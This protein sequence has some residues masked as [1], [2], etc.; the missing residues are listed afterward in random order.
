MNLLRYRTTE[1]GQ[2]DRLERKVISVVAEGAF[3]PDREPGSLYFLNKK[4]EINLISS[5]RDHSLSFHF[6]QK[7]GN[8][9]PGSAQ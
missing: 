9:F 1:G 8:N 4:G 3:P 5:H 6:L 7:P 2:E